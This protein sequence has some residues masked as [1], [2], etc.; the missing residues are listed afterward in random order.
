MAVAPPSRPGPS[1]VWI[2]DP[3]VL[4]KPAP[5]YPLLH[6]GTADVFRGVPGGVSPRGDEPADTRR[7]QQLRGRR[8]DGPGQVATPA[9]WSCS[10]AR[11]TRSPSWTCSCSR[12]NGDFDAYRPRLARYVKGV[13]DDTIAAAVHRL[14]ELY[15]EVARRE[16]RLAELGAK[17][18]TRQ[19]ARAA[20]RTCGPIVALFSECHE[21]FGHDE[22]GA[23]AAELATKTVK[24]A[25]KT[26]D[27]AAVRHPVQP[28][29]GDPAE[30]R[31]AGPRER[32]LLRQDLAVAM[33]GSS[34]TGRSRR[35][36]AR[37]SCGPAGTAA[38]R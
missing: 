19:L 5:E 38:R 13:E 32:L 20:P 11:W 18:V 37:P 9:G 7:R 14:H 10:A 1:S 21:L 17:K 15:G 28:Q 24:R 25:R 3:G 6:E 36:S 12:N 8:P 27:H 33:T 34:A 16:A 22:H 26:G 30:A 4:S 2:A 31:R 23:M 35:G 29:G